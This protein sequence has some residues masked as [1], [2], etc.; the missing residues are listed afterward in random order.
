MPAEE[1][2]EAIVREIQRGLR[3]RLADLYERHRRRLYGYLLRA[4]HDPALADDVFQEAWMKVIERVDG[5]DPARGSFRAWIYRIASN[6]LID[7]ARYDTVRRGAELD[8]P[9]AETEGVRR[10]DLQ[11]SPE[12]GPDRRAASSEAGRSLD[13]ALVRLPPRQRLAVL[14][15]HQQGLSYKELAVALRAPEG[16]AK[17]LVH[18]GVHA[19]RELMGDNPL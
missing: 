7:R 8:A 1:S 13:E 11:P 19:L 4:A 10:I 15:R 2:D 16:T 3:R 5:F 14:L 6:A 17:A 18:R 12:A 9:V